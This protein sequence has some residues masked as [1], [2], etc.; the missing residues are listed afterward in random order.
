MMQMTLAHKQAFEARRAAG[1]QS[2]PVSRYYLDGWLEHRNASPLY[3]EAAA[4]HRLLSHVVQPLYPDE[5]IPGVFQPREPVGFHYGSATYVNEELVEAY[6]VQ[7]GLEGAA[8]QAFLN[9]VQLVREARYRPANPTLFTPEENASIEA[10][11]AS[12]TWFGG[13]MVID[14]ETILSQGLDFYERAIDAAFTE[15]NREFYEAMRLQL[16]AVRVYLTR[17]A[18]RARECADMPGYERARFERMGQDLMH[19]AHRPPESFRQGITLVWVLHMLNGSDSF[20]RF[21]DYLLGLYRQDRTSGA[22]SLEEAEELLACLCIKVEEVNQIQN[23]TLGGCDA[24]GEPQYTELTELMLRVTACL[25]YKGPNLCLRVRPDMPQST[26]QAALDCLGTGIGL[27]A[28]YNERIYIENFERTGIAPEVARGFCLAGCSQVMLPGQCNFVNDIGMLNA[29]KVFELALNDGADPLT[30]RQVGPHTGRAGDFEGYEQLERAF[31]DQLDY[32]CELE[33]SI[34]DK[35]TVYRRSCEGYTMRT[36]FM[37]DCIARGQSIFEGGARYNNIELEVIGI[38]NCADCLTAVRQAVYERGRLTMDELLSVLARNFEGDEPLR[39]YLLH[40]VDKFGND[41]PVVDA[42]RGR[43]AQRVFENFNRRP[44]VLGG[45]YV[46]G[47][48]IFTAHEATGRAVGATPDGRRAHQVLADSAG[49]SQGMDLNGP[50]ALMNSVLQTPT[51]FLLTSV[52][53][54]LR[55]MASLFN[56]PGARERVQ[57]L[58]TSFFER[59]GMQVQVNVC[60]AE[61]LKRALEDPEAYR[62]LVVRVGGYSDYFVNLSPALQQEIICRTE[63]TA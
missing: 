4:V 42:L 32:F 7:Q 55:F 59:G 25:R 22:L 14:Y 5:C 57:A 20:G 10:F 26:W 47:E 18:Q 45:V 21:D 3:R 38:T 13:H 43:I 19:I 41:R 31:F 9:E 56:Q 62:S 52:V 28:L 35:D 34:N 1:G 54:N 11:A 48:V 30:G 58:L 39:Q 8:R 6:A 33:A 27:P 2:E 63:H 46:P 12:S 60:D 24:K 53:L 37:R 36:L 15:E 50:T 17:Y 40:R 16:D 49:A 61:E 51:S 23:M 44:S 29:A